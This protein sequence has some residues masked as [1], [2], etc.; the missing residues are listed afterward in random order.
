MALLMVMAQTDQVCYYLLMYL[1]GAI[2]LHVRSLVFKMWMFFL[3]SKFGN[4]ACLTH[5]E[6]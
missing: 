3:G 4:F 1:K 6:N 2:L 5:E